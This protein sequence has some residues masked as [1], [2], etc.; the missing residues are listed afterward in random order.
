[1]ELYIIRH[2]I[3][4]DRSAEINEF[5]RYLTDE[6]KNE[7]K[8]IG[9]GLKKIGI[10]F[11]LI[12]SSPLIRAKQTAEIIAHET[13]YD[14]KKIKETEY[15]EIGSNWKKAFDLID[16]DEHVAFI[17]HN[18]MLSEMVCAILCGE[19]NGNTPMKKAGVC[20]ISMISKKIFS[21]ELKWFIPPK[22]FK[23]LV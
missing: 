7:L 11:D 6:G 17:G 13:G 3:A 22:I 2:G 19:L 4:I 23:S 1:M 14:I 10:N 21:G 5:D 12:M 15:L 18:P 8:I 16:N 9:Q 20:R